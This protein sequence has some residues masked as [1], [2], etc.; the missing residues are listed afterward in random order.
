ML[1]M[2]RNVLPLRMD[3]YH[4]GLH[5]PGK[6]HGRRAGTPIGKRNGIMNTLRRAKERH[7]DLCRKQEVWHTFYPAADRAD[8]LANGFGTL[9][10]L[11]EGHL[12]PGADIPLHPHHDVEIITY[13][14]EG[15]LEHEDSMGHSGIIRAGEFQCMTAGRG[16]SHS[17][18]NPSR[19][20]W[21]HIFQI[22]LRP[23]ETGLESSHEQK[24]FCAAARQGEWCIVASPDAQRGSLRMHLDALLYSTMLDPGQHMVHE[25][26]R[27]RSAW[28]H[29]V[30]GTVTLGDIVL[31]TGD[32]IGIMADR[33]VS[34]T[35]QQETEILLLDL[36]AA[37]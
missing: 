16:M 20:D 29:L 4:Q 19:T 13:V 27:G 18:A 24:R 25:L 9:E 30:Q 21:A 12:A 3:V 1:G 28:L 11:N 14:H 33:A 35:A 31:N 34:L 10:M 7:H 36:G 6:Q 23:S 37:S 26:W 32:G 22:H 15:A 5:K 2:A 8:P 17:E